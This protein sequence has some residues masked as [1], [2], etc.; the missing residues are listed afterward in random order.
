MIKSVIIKNFKCIKDLELQLAP[1]TIFVGPN[2]SGKTGILEAIALMSQAIRGIGNGHLIDAREGDLVRIEDINAL[3]YKGE[4]KN[5]LSLGFEVELEEDESSY[6][7]KGILEDLK[8]VSSGEAKTFLSKLKDKKIKNV[9]YIY[10]IKLAPYEC[11]HLFYFDETQIKYFSDGSNIEAFPKFISL[12]DERRFLPALYAEG[13]YLDFSENLFKIVRRRFEKIYYLSSR[14]DVMNWYKRAED[15]ELSYVGREGEYTLDVLSRLM[16]P[17]NDE[18]RWPYELICEE[19]GVKRIWAGIERGSIL[20]SNYKDPWLN[21]TH[22]L[23]SLGHGARQLIPIIAQL[24]IGERGS[25]ILIDEP[26]ISLHPSYQVKL[27]ILFGNAVMEGKQVLLTTHSSYFPLS[28]HKL[29]DGSLK[30]E[31]QTTIGRKERVIKLNVNDVMVYHVDRSS[32]GYT[33]VHRLEL[34]ENGLKEGI[35]SFTKVEIDLLSRFIKGT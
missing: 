23:P 12:G 15:K 30:I 31:G 26:E 33:V 5:L 8:K 1:L 17:E 6:V 3:F 20:T 16:R 13:H 19:F 28:L 29:F 14:R 25:V 35:P 34:D 11:K 7:R 10:S 18:K 22:K 2:G 27:S 24:A 21:S 32:K 9:K 4:T